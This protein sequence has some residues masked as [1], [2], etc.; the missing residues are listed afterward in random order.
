MPFKSE[1]LLANLYFCIWFDYMN[2]YLYVTALGK[3]KDFMKTTIHEKKVPSRVDEDWLASVG[4]TDRKNDRRFIPILK[5][6]GFI[7]DNGSP[8]K[9]YEEYRD[10]D[11][12]KEVMKKALK[13]AYPDLF[14]TYD[15]PFTESDAN[16]SNLIKNKKNYSQKVAILA[17]RTFK[18]LATASEIIADT[19]ATIQK[20]SPRKEGKTKV[21]SREEDKDKAKEVSRESNGSSIDIEPVSIVINIQLVLPNT[22]DKEVYSNL[23]SELRKF[24]SKEKQNEP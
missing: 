23:F 8:T 14:S 7:G 5:E 12:S 17:T 16:I 15:D 19:D 6:L 10:K 4:Y 3:F 22:T 11:K 24:I 21:V 9:A 1:Y 2:E 18:T 13:D 20:R